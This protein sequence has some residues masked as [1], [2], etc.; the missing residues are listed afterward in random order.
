MVPDGW[1]AV[2][3][4]ADARSIASSAWS[5]WVPVASVHRCRCSSLLF[6]SPKLGGSFSMDGARVR[7]GWEKPF[8]IQIFSYISVYM[9]IR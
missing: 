5:Y 1:L 9:S 7:H 3:V 8:L 2:A 6:R 4:A